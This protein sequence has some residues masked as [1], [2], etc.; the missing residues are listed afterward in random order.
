[1]IWGTGVMRIREGMIKEG[2]GVCIKDNK[3][4]D[5]PMVKMASNIIY[6]KELN[7]KRK[8]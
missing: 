2:H 3:F 6:K 5:G 1:M 4:I 8:S 7:N